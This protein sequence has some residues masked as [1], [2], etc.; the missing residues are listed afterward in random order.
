MPLP[1]GCQF[2]LFPNLSSEQIAEKIG[3]SAAA[4]QR[5]IKRLRESKVISADVSIVNPK[6]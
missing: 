2:A 5:R 1:V 3:L 6:L 4:V